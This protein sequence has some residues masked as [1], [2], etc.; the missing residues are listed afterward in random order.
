[1]FA[2]LAFLTPLP[3]FQRVPIGI[4][5]RIVFIA[6]REGSFFGGRSRG[7][8]FLVHRFDAELFL[9]D[10]QILE[11]GFGFG[12]L[13]RFRF[14]E[15]EIGSE[16]VVIK[17][18]GTRRLRAA[19]GASL[20]CGRLF[21]FAR[22]PARRSLG[23]AGVRLPASAWFGGRLLGLFRGGRTL[24][25]VQGEILGRDERFAGRIGA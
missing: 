22:V 6:D 9:F 3:V 12:R 14:V 20:F 4:V 18:C 13:I 17:R 15:I 19:S 25:F 1:V 16:I 2:A 10:L 21:L 11:D 5:C 8:A 7:I 24:W 23:F